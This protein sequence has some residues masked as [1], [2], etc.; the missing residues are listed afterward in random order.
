M[1]HYY[2]VDDDGAI[3]GT[4]DT[5]DG[6]PDDLS[7]IESDLQLPSSMVAF[8]DGAIV[9]RPEPPSPEHRWNNKEWIAPPTIEAV[10]GH[11]WAGLEAALE[12]SSAWDKA[13]R[14]SGKTVRAGAAFNLLLNTLTIGHRVPRLEFAISELRAAMESAASIDPFTAEDI[15]FINQCLGDNGFDLVL[16]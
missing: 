2:L 1:A 12:G 11:N 3:A 16:E 13:Y 7:A 5:P 10:A 9:P 15:A 14:A 8:V 4:S 6:L